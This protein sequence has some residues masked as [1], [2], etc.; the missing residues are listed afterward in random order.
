MESKFVIYAE[1]G[2]GSAA[3]QNPVARGRIGKGFGLRASP[4]AKCPS[5]RRPERSIQQ[6]ADSSCGVVQEGL[7]VE[8]ASGRARGCDASQSRL[9]V[10]VPSLKTDITA[11]TKGNALPSDAKQHEWKLQKRTP[12][13]ATSYASAAGIQR[14]STSNQKQGSL[15][16]KQRRCVSHTTSK[17]VARSKRCIGFRDIIFGTTEFDCKIALENTKR[18]GK[19]ERDSRSATAFDLHG[20]DDPQAEADDVRQASASVSLAA[21][22]KGRDQTRTKS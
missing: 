7:E 16:K 21:L 11:P 18:R 15:A 13:G 19:I 1:T 10:T 12:A 14:S 20:P 4:T 9:T 17:T 22:F 6:Q 3:H 5:L 2:A 8:E